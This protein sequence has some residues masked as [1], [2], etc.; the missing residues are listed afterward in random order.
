MADREVAVALPCAPDLPLPAS[1]S[2][3]VAFESMNVW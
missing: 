2:C 3:L 1:S